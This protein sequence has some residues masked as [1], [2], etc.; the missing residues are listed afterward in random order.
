MATGKQ[1]FS[2]NTSAAIFDA[3]LHGNPPAARQWNPSLPFEL[4]RI[5]G[6]LLEKD[7]DLRY[8][9]AADLR[10]D[11]KRLHRDVIS[12]HTPAHVAPELGAAEESKTRHLAWLGG[13][14]ILIVSAA[15]TARFY[16]SPAPKYS[17][18]P[19][20]LVPF[21]SSPGE[22]WSPAFSPDGNEIAFTWQGENAKD[23]NTS[24]IYVQLVGTG[25]PL[26]LTTAAA[27]D[28]FPAWS[29]DGRFIAFQR[30]T[31][32]EH[33][34]AGHGAY[35][36]VPALGGPER[37]L[38]DA[39]SEILGG[40]GLSWSPD[41][42]YLAVADR[43]PKA[44][45]VAATGI[46]F[47]SLESGE[48][49]PSNIELPVPYVTNPTFSPDGKY[50]A[51]IAGSGFLSNDVY[52]APV[53]GGKARA[54]TSVRST[55]NGVAWTSDGRELVFDS[56]HEG[57]PTLWRVPFTGGDLQALSVAA[58]FA[59]Q[60]SIALRG[61]RLALLRYAVDSNIW[62]ASLAPSDHSP[63]S[64]ITA[65]TQE[66]SDVAISPDGQRLAFRSNRTG[67]DQ[68]YVSKTDGSNPSS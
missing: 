63:P 43:G 56:T 64:R 34:G 10:G 3:I 28:S 21:T 29:P 35:Y 67:T 11:L 47:I 45:T 19:P 66:D 32:G 46:F 9:T 27:A 31:E 25:T 53:S 20:R 30:D 12:G 18:P 4:E 52:V 59:S 55:M 65:A 1:A 68:I 39:Y 2:G 57:L 13:A 51:F 16:V 8:Q 60:P 36:I 50:L 14:I 54:L 26:R 48:R 24:S 17:G 23:L 41:G 61:N 62:K 44:G 58:D 7:A 49:Q 42:K 38:A 22:K 6:R 15:I 40:G 5:V 33:N 37:K